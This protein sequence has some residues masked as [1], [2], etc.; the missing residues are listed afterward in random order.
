MALYPLT[1][2][3]RSGPRL[4][5]FALLLLFVT[6]AYANSLQ[7]PLI[8][9][10]RIFLGSNT[11]IKSLESI[12][13]LFVSEWWE[14]TD[15]PLAD[16][17]YRPL[18]VATFALN[19]AL[20]GLHPFGFHL[21][22]VVLHLLVSWLIYLLALELGLSLVPA[23]IAAL[24]FAVHPLHTEVVACVTNRTEELMAGGVLASVWL[25]SRGYRR[26]SLAA[27]GCALCSKEQAVMLPAIL[28]L[29]DLC[30]GRWSLQGQQ[31]GERLRCAIQ[32]YRG[33][34]AILAVY[35]LARVW[36]F[37]SLYSPVYPVHLS[38]LE[39]TTGSVWLLSVLKLAGTYLQLWL[40]PSALSVDYSYNAVPLAG[41][42]LDP[43]VWWGVFAWGGLLGL[44]ALSYVGTRRALFCVGLVVLAFL[45]ASNLLVS[46]GTPMA[47]RVFYLPSAGLCLLVGVGGQ[48]L[49][50]VLGDRQPTGKHEE[51]DPARARS[52]DLSLKWLSLVVGLCF[53]LTVRTVL[54]NQDWQ[55][56]ERLFRSSVQARPSNAKGHA[57]LGDAL[58]NKGP[59]FWEEALQE[60]QTALRLYPD[61]FRTDAL[62]ANN[63]G[64]LF[65]KLGRMP[66][67]VAAY[68][69]ASSLEPRWE[70]PLYSLGLAYARLWQLDKAEAAWRRA[71]SIQPGDPQIYSSLSRLYAELG[72]YQDALAAADAA[73]Q[74]APQLLWAHYNRAVALE[75]LGRY[76]DARSAYERFLSLNPPQEAAI[77]ITRKL[78]DLR[79]RRLN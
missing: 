31:W 54:R 75:G 59:K 63:L 20:G 72:R 68:E 45:P 70:P 17:R 47:E 2:Q 40:W 56:E 12:P 78:Q 22:N 5:V 50:H 60:Y 43:N 74:R 65:M 35:L 51:A 79:A 55:T 28:V 1:D 62:F 39:Y 29:F 48:W 44:G 61:F 13:R 30:T 32:R 66:E 27:Y 58:T 38:P 10:D 64:N 76:A 41:S 18:V 7:N 57:L 26:W 8:F 73:L 36:I 69:Q 21:V 37:G 77:E 71:Q 42:W 15:Q 9:G 33:Y 46:V 16:R 23:A 49:G 19:F 3:P 11:L 24:V 25:A 14:G 67:A 4:G 53:A 34:V 6:L 52:A